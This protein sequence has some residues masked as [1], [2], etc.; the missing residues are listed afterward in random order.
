MPRMFEKQSDN[1]L[2]FGLKLRH[3]GWRQLN[4]HQRTLTHNYFVH[5]MALTMYMKTKQ[6]QLY[7]R[8]HTLHSCSSTK[9]GTSIAQMLVTNLMSSCVSSAHNAWLASVLRSVLSQLLDTVMLT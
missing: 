4:S 7:M 5:V 6:L 9:S 3:D 2:S 1:T 8:R